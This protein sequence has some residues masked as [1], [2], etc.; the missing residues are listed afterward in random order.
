MCISFGG[1]F[2]WKKVF[3]VY[4]TFPPKNY[5]SDKKNFQATVVARWLMNKMAQIRFR[6]NHLF[7]K[8]EI[9]NQ[10]IYFSSLYSKNECVTSTRESR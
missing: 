4:K 6:K 7:M 1:V 3:F 5:E 2:K 8:Y 10:K 9:V